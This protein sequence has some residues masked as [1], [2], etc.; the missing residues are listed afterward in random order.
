MSISKNQKWIIIDIFIASIIIVCIGF[1]LIHNLSSILKSFPTNLIYIFSTLASITIGT[2]YLYLKYPFKVSLFGFGSQNIRNTII[3]GSIGCITL[4]LINFPYA[5]VLGIKNIP[6]EHFIEIQHG[7]HF[8]ILFL[9]I[10]VIM[11]PFIEELFYRAFLFRIVKNELSL[12]SGYIV[13]TVFFWVGH[14]FSTL[15]LINSLILC[16]IYKKTGGVGAS[17]IAH[18]LLNFVWYTAVYWKSVI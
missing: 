9:I 17:I 7:M 8:V 11:I 5:I 6:H 12:V 2:S 10:A 3:W 13:S 4:V 16:Y 1:F 15:S 18:S 14:S